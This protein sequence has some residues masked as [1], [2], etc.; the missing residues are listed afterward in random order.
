M[1]MQLQFQAQHFGTDVRSSKNNI[2]GIFVVSNTA[3]H[4]YRQ[5][6]TAAGTGSMTALDAEL[7]LAAK[8]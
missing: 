2:V 3:D 8:E 7:Y 4:L 1:M 6:I 5:A